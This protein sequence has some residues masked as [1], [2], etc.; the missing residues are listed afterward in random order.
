MKYRVGVL[1]RIRVRLGGVC[2]QRM[3]SD[4]SYLETLAL[5]N[6]PGL[7]GARLGTV[8]CTLTWEVNVLFKTLDKWL[9]LATIENL[10]VKRYEPG[11]HPIFAK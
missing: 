10:S 5:L 2:L 6:L 7:M 1:N 8:S 4:T 9:V 11:S 3:R